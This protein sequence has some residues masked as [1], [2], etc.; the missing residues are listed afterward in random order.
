MRN[1][2]H[3]H[4]VMGRTP[5]LG[6]VRALQRRRERG[7]EDFEIDQFLEPRRRIADFRKFLVTL[8][9]IEKSRPPTIAILPA[10]RPKVNHDNAKSARFLEVS[11]RPFAKGEIGRDSDPGSFVDPADQMEEQ[12]PAGLGEGEEAA[13]IVVPRR[14]E[15]RRK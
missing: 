4:G 8:I 7:A 14:L 6:A 3:R 1:L 15:F 13:Q 10:L 12:L 5:A 11:G 9:Q 2:E